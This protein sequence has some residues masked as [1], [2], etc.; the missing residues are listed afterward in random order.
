M[1]VVGH[2][3]SFGCVGDSSLLRATETRFLCYITSFLAVWY[4]FIGTMQ[5]ILLLPRDK[6]LNFEPQIAGTVLE[7]CYSGVNNFVCNWTFRYSTS[8]HSL[9]LKNSNSMLEGVSTHLLHLLSKQ[10]SF[11]IDWVYHIVADCI[12]SYGGLMHHSSGWSQLAAWLRYP[13]GCCILFVMSLF[14]STRIL[15]VV[16]FL[17]G[18]ACFVQG[19]LILYLVE[20][21]ASGYFWGVSLC[22]ATVYM[23]MSVVYLRAAY[24]LCACVC[25]SY[26]EDAIKY[27]T[28]DS[29]YLSPLAFMILFCCVPTSCCPWITTSLTPVLYY[30]ELVRAMDC[31]DY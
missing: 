25:A 2:N 13:I 18:V 6:I 19:H 3:S 24:R 20:W 28:T 9:F 26:M 1:D 4:V 5:R 30:A 22:Q 10:M 23:I 11:H 15:A 7:T 27:R 31:I 14:P 21:K 17:R 8:C 16:V 29:S 12:L